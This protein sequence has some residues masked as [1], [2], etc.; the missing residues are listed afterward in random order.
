MERSMKH[1]LP[2]A[3]AAAIAIAVAA[4]LAASAHDY[5]FGDLVIIHPHAPATAPGAP[6]GAGYLTISNEGAAADRLLAV[7]A[8][9][10]AGAK[11]HRT[12]MKNDIMRM[13]PVEGGLE[14]PAG[15]IVELEPGGYHIMFTGLE[16]PLADGERRT[17]TLTFERAGTVEIEFHVETDAGA[18]AGGAHDGHGR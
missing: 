6:T 12:T 16:G 18:G 7:S 4:S 9:F 10:A 5:T 17:V 8:V 2:A 11:I 13:R 1:S 3:I 15:D 14:L